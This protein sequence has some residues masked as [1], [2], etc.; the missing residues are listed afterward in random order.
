MKKSKIV[1]WL[2]MIIFVLFAFYVGSLVTFMAGE[3]SGFWTLAWFT[4]LGFAW[5]LG[6]SMWEFIK[7]VM[8]K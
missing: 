8:Q 5:V 7:E 4:V 3:L 1:M 2:L 6:M